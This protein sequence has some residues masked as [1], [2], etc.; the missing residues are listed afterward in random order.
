MFWHFLYRLVKNTKFAD[1]SHVQWKS[2]S[3][4]YITNSRN[5]VRLQLMNFIWYNNL[6]NFR[7]F[8]NCNLIFSLACCHWLKSDLKL[9]WN[10]Y[11]VVLNC[12]KKGISAHLLHTETT[13]QRNFNSWM[14]KFTVTQKK[15]HL[16]VGKIGV[17][18]N[19][20]I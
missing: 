8:Q 15:S 20:I 9:L 17:L 12:C 10:I 18:V 11:I 5:L 3:E 4:S 19:F 16:E 7:G 6:S 2:S 14:M 1:Y 13:V